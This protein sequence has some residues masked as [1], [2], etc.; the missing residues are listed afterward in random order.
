MC[1]KFLDL[2]YHRMPLF[3]DFLM[4]IYECIFSLRVD[5]WTIVFIENGSRY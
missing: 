5:G 4:P 3:F 1:F 2:D